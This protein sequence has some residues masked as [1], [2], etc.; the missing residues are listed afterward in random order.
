MINWPVPYKSSARV[1]AAFACLLLAASGPFPILNVSV[2]AVC[3]SEAS[4]QLGRALSPPEI[5][6]HEFEGIGLAH[7]KRYYYLVL[8][9]AYLKEVGFWSVYFCVALLGL[10][11]WSLRT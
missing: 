3:I 6:T 9:G 4:L 5:C 7:I 2:T 1:L 10:E 11:Y 8:V